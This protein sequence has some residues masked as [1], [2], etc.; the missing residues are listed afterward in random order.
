MSLII[1]KP[2]Q[3]PPC[4]RQ[5][6]KKNDIG[7]TY[8][9]QVIKILNKTKQKQSLSNVHRIRCKRNLTTSNVIKYY[10]AN[11]ILVKTL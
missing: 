4:T 11:T 7:L 9:I 8:N 6:S 3:L 1:S 2:G 10:L 5:Q